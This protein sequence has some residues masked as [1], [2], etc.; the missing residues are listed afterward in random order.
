MLDGEIVCGPE[1]VTSESQM[2]SMYL[3]VVFGVGD[4][5]RRQSHQD[6]FQRD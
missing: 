4:V 1:A 5:C 6:T 2:G 3:V